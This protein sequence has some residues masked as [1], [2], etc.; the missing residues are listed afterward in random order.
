M[1]ECRNYES[2]DKIKDLCNGRQSCLIDTTD[3]PT[4]LCDNA[5][6]ELHVEWK[7]VN[8]RQKVDWCYGIVSS[9]YNHVKF[10][11]LCRSYSFIKSDPRSFQ[12]LKM[13]VVQ[14]MLNSC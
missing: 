14:M 4:G 11:I 1:P 7:C 13:I 6:A 10:I 12:V 2:N 9:A 3:V 8:N 5:T